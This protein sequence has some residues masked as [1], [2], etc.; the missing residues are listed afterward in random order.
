MTKLDGIRTH[1]LGDCLL[2]TGDPGQW[3][4]MN[5]NFIH[6]LPQSDTATEVIS[7]ARLAITR[8][9]LCRHDSVH[10]NCLGFIYNFLI[11]VPDP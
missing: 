11:S 2:G 7:Y 10:A 8:N 4:T 5:P 9:I 3:P 6:E 1:R